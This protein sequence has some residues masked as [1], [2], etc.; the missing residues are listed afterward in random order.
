MIPHGGGSL[1]AAA[2]LVRFLMNNK[3]DLKEEDLME[4]L[5]DNEITN[6]DPVAEAFKV[7][8]RETSGG[9]GAHDLQ[10][11]FGGT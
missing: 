11:F 1:T 6:F 4:L 2:P 10:S 8:R 3:L 5:M 9:E 7:R